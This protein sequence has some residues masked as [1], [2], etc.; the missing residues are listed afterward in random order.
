MFQHIHTD[1]SAKRR[2]EHSP[3]YADYSPKGKRICRLLTE[4]KSTVHVMLR[5]LTKSE[6][7]HSP[8]Y[9]DYLP[10]GKRSTVHDIQTTHQK[11]REAYSPEYTD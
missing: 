2:A 4:G 5:L 9:T 1:Y 3:G 11:G 6:E 8:R 10:K 7:K